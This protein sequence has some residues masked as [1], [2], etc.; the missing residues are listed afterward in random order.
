MVC[1][2]RHTKTHVR[3]L[4]LSLAHSRVH[5]HI[6][7]LAAHLTRS[8]KPRPLP[9]L[10]NQARERERDSDITRV[11]SQS[12]WRSCDDLPTEAEDSCELSGWGGGGATGGSNTWDHLET[13]K[14][15][16]RWMDGWVEVNSSN[17]Q[18]LSG[19]G[20]VWWEG[21]TAGGQ[22]SGVPISP[23]FA[24]PL[25]GLQTSAAAPLIGSRW[26]PLDAT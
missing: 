11:V 9:P 26:K 14:K 18:V 22:T 23:L 7:T 17:C 4:S 13:L 10:R 16:G 24:V 8:T 19:L 3:T 20:S 5:A 2:A 15:V 25:S 21:P 1:S 6:C 12:Q